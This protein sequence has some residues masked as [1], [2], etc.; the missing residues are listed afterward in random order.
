[1]LQPREN[2]AVYGFE[3]MEQRMIAGWQ[4]GKLPHAM[5]LT[6]PKGIGKATFAYRLACFILAGGAGN[7]ALFGPQ[8]LSLD[9]E[10][11][12]FKRVTAGSHGNLFV[13]T[14][15]HGSATQQIKVEQIRSLNE[16][17][18]LTVGDGDW[19]V[20]IIDSADEM[21]L[22][23]ANALLKNLEE[24][25]EKTLFLLI[26]HNSG[27][28]LPTIES[29]CRKWRMK[30]HD[31]T[32]F[33]KIVHS[34]IPD[35]EEITL[36]KLHLLSDGSPGFACELYEANT[37]E[38]YQQLT[39]LM[40]QLPTISQTSLVSL[41]GQLR[42]KKQINLWQHF[43]HCLDLFFQRTHRQSFGGH[44][45]DTLCEEERAAQQVLFALHP[46]ERLLSLHRQ[47]LAWLSRGDALNNDRQQLMT[48]VL[49]ALNNQVR[50]T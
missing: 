45:D 8:E 40:A 42:D 34:I 36:Q 31:I 13:L 9:E 20:I 22:N 14:P 44:D 11:P 38:L 17:L 41:V 35:I 3:E 24:P 5:L 19:R 39:G 1:M 16:S 32:V 49:H 28:L 50:L 46:P 7:D 48:S 25:P 10:H 47:S 4:S 43:L 23:A 27:K 18:A 15:E 30:P 2:P 29:R 33:N 6:G 21:N 37:I 26:S 12:V